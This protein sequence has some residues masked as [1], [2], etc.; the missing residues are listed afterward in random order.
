M[1][2]I[3]P[4]AT[5]LGPNIYATEPVIVAKLEADV[6]ILQD[7]ERRIKFLSS[8]CQNWFNFKS[9]NSTNTLEDLGNFLSQW[10][11]AILNQTTGEIQTARVEK[12]NNSITI[13]L[14][15]YHPKFTFD[16]LVLGVKLFTEVDRL[17]P[18]EIVK[19]LKDFLQAAITFHPDFQT[20]ILI[21]YSEKKGIP[22][23]SYLLGTR[24]WQ[25]GWGEKS[26]VLFESSPQ[27][28]SAL[29]ARW[30][31]DKMLS[32]QIFSRLGAPIA[33]SVMVKNESD[34]PRAASSVGFPCVTKPLFGSRSVGVTTNI[35]N[36]SE[37]LSGFKHAQQNSPAEIMIEKHIEGE[38]HRIMIMQGKFWRAIKRSRPFITGDGRSSI[39]QLTEKLIASFPSTKTPKDF[40]G[41][42]P[43]DQEFHQ[44]LSE[45]GF[46]ENSVSPVGKRI[47]IRKIPLLSTGATYEDVTANIHPDVRLMSESLA[48]NFGILNCGIDYITQDI[49]QSCFG[50]GV[51]L[52]INLTPG[53]RVPLMAGVSLDEIG[54]AVLGDKPSRLPLTL[55]I[56]PKEYHLE[57]L[58]AKPT[59][60][61]TGWI[62]NQAYGIDELKFTETKMN[63]FAAFDL[64]V[65]HPTLK[66]IFVLCEPSELIQHGLIAKYITRTVVIAG[67]NLDINWLNLLKKHSEILTENES[68][69][70]LIANISSSKS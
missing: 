41:P 70:K 62:G 35:R 45:Q 7:S 9:N 15:H 49:N 46:N 59:S 40:T 6:E 69:T 37:L 10:A 27:N 1:I 58:A 4:I 5:F 34:L 53:L 43:L 23:R 60:Q 48:H 68:V 25:Y 2:K 47:Y 65:R 55:I 12:I 36:T 3:T 61:G 20:K 16:A 38:V 44:S 31:S 8:L 18:D 13:I 42:P 54:A 52:E 56:A 67:S 32:K 19:L 63:L 26:V 64:I 11:Q 22:Y 33:P 57:L 29:G 39:R 66:S 28:D 51:F 30:S 14:G 21:D 24:A 50:H 17:K